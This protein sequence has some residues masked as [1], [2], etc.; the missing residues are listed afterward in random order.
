[1]EDDKNNEAQKDQTTKSSRVK[2]KKQT[3][4]SETSAQDDKKEEKNS[5]FK[6][7]TVKPGEEEKNNIE[8]VRTKSKKPTKKP[9]PE[10]QG[11]RTKSKKPTKKPDG[12]NQEKRVKSKKGTK[13]AQDKEQNKEDSK[14]EEENKT[15]L[16][17]KKSSKLTLS[18]PNLSRKEVTP[19]VIK[20]GHHLKPRVII[21]NLPK[22]AKRVKVK[23][24]YKREEYELN[25]RNM[26]L[27][28]FRKELQNCLHMFLSDIQIFYQGK[29]YQSPETDNMKIFDIYKDETTYL[30]I[31][32]KSNVSMLENLSV[33][34]PKVYS[35]RVIVKNVESPEEFT[36]EIDTFF[37]NLMIEKDFHLV[38][39]PENTLSIGFTYPDLAFDFNRYIW[40]LKNT[41]IKY[42][43]IS[44]H[45][46]LAA[47]HKILAENL[48]T[49]S[50]NSVNKSTSF[51]KNPKKILFNSALYVGLSG[52]YITEEERRRKDY[53]ESKK[54]WVCSQDFISCAKG[55]ESDFKN[56]YIYY[57]VF[58]KN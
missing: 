21:P 55:I 50:I 54:K 34:Y 31:K 43:N 56:K 10:G 20:A 45:L 38:K 3:K 48:S 44:S 40:I 57:L 15:L 14:K 2:S 4:K 16:K 58:E 52:D 47:K 26:T 13:K 37:S 41:N 49:D 29:E 36:K 33:I 18:E 11:N 27:E 9:E 35:N 8:E 39:L 30:E 1:M 12:D 46:K 7:P 53:I 51:R 22:R 24:I 42:K 17:V 6:K 23:F 28:K 19:I 25:I 32:K 5:K